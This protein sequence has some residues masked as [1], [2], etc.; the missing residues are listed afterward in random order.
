M[1]SCLR[2][3]RET[4]AALKA[5]LCLTGTNFL[6]QTTEEKKP[7]TTLKVLLCTVKIGRAHV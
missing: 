5:V 4:V 7:Q 2:G 3:E 1:H 6:A